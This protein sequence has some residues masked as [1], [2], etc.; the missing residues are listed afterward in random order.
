M[1]IYTHGPKQINS[2]LCEKKGIPDDSYYYPHICSL[3]HHILENKQNIN[4]IRTNIHSILPSVM[5]KY[6]FINKLITY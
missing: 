2:F 3:C 4:I 1:A 5:L 6:Q